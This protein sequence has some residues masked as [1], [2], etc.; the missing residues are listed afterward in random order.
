MAVDDRKS[1][2][3]LPGTYALRFGKTNSSAARS[4]SGARGHFKQ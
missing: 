4:T 3:E 1:F 2:F